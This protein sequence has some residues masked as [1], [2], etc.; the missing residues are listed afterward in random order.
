MSQ[1][2]HTNPALVAAGHR[3]HQPSIVCGAGVATCVVTGATSALAVG[4]RIRVRRTMPVVSRFVIPFI[5]AIR[6]GDVPA[7]LLMRRNRHGKRTRR[8]HH[9]QIRGRKKPEELH[10]PAVES[11]DCPETPHISTRVCTT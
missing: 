1:P 4:S 7:I 5:C 10:G 2:R 9:A 6:T 3:R 8:E 11:P